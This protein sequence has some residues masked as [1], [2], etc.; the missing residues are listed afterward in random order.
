MVAF[1][2]CRTSYTHKKKF[3]QQFFLGNKQQG[4]QTRGNINL[5]HQLDFY[6]NKKPKTTQVIDVH[7]ADYV[8]GTNKVKER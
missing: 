8:L 4:Q 3:L 1:V 5:I 7:I 2:C 6:N